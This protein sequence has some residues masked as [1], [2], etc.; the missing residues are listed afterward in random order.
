[1]F[2][3]PVITTRQALKENPKGKRKRVG[4]ETHGDTTMKLTPRRWV[5]LGGLETLAQDGDSWADLV[6]IT[7]PRKDDIYK[8]RVVFRQL[9]CL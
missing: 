1:M 3:K 4:Q 2:G 6:D 9:F 7:C 8:K 5:T